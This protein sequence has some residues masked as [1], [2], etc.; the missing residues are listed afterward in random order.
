MTANRPR[1]WRLAAPGL[2]ACIVLALAGFVAPAA[3]QETAFHP[4][5]FLDQA[6]NS[7][8]L[9]QP[10]GEETSDF[11]TRVGVGL[12]V[13]RNWRSGSLSFEYL[14]SYEWYRDNEDLNHDEHRLR[15]GVAAAPARRSALDYDLAWSRTQ[16]QGTIEDAETGD[17]VLVPRSEQDLVSTSLRFNREFSQKMSW[18]AAAEA[19]R[20]THTLLEDP[21]ADPTTGG[22]EDRSQYAGLLGLDR[23]VS[24]K[25][26]FGVEA[27]WDLYDLESS[28]E[29]DVAQLFLTWTR[30]VPESYDLSFRV[31]SFRRESDPG[32]IGPPLEESDESGVTYAASVAKL[33]PRS[34]LGVSA[35][36]GPSA[37]GAI[38]GT[39]TN[40]TAALT[41][42]GSPNP[43]WDW[44][45][46][47]VYTLREPTNPDVPEIETLGGGGRVEWRPGRR[48]ALRLAASYTERT[49]DDPTMDASV[50]VGTLSV[51]WLPRGPERPSGGGG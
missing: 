15:F 36:H 40:T 16:P 48:A 23:A 46:N 1:A 45:L 29:E 6:Y 25:D 7:N 10:E 24:R 26:R 4:E 3:A 32:E 41:W 14:P 13:H 17:L 12:P 51:V 37:G 20:T 31:G 47:S 22:L 35:N 21:A 34:R 33:F 42:A 39:S 50:F 30:A 18:R 43:R 19:S 49:T 9:T 11:I 8:M 44:A 28:G 38:V 2:S 5:L 27:R